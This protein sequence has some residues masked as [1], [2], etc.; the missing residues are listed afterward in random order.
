MKQNINENATKT[1]FWMLPERLSAISL[2]LTG[3]LSLAIVIVISV[4]L[5]SC[6][7]YEYVP[8]YEESSYSEDINSLLMVLSNYTHDDDKINKK[9]RVLI[10][11][12]KVDKNDKTYDVLNPRFTIIG[13]NKDGIEYF[14]DYRKEGKLQNYM[15]TH[16]FASTKANSKQIFDKFYVKTSYTLVRENKEDELKVQTYSQNLLNITNEEIDKTTKDEILEQ[17]NV[18]TNHAVRRKKTSS[19]Y[20][21]YVDL[22]L[23]RNKLT[24]YKVDYQLFGIDESGEI[25][26]LVGLYNISTT[27]QYSYT[28]GS[29]IPTEMKLTK[30]IAKAN[31]LDENGNTNMYYSVLTA[32]EE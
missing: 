29:S 28:R 10:G 3:L 17:V 32:K 7:D 30:F 1:S 5:F 16:D 27:S 13:E 22:Y 4:F 14:S 20:T 21:I 9:N 11:Y 15:S 6:R 23:N 26:T 31:Y 12:S 18:F 24:K 2:F 19:G 8:D 25:Y